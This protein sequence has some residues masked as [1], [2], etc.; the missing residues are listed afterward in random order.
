MTHLDDRN[1]LPR[2]LGFFD[3]TTTVVGAIIGTGI[4]LKASAISQLLPNPWHV[5][6][7]WAVAGALSLFGA[8]VITEL[9]GMYPHSGGLYLYLTEAFG[10]FVG[11]LFGWAMLALIQTG[12]LSG[13]AAGV[14]QATSTLLER[15]GHAPLAADEQM[16]GAM[17][18]V[19]L[20]TLINCVS[21]RAGASVQNFLTVLKSLGLVVLLAG[22]ALGGKASTANWAAGPP[23]THLALGAA[24]GL[25]MIKALWV[26]DGWIDVSFIAGEVE[27]PQRNL[28]RAMLFGMG[29]IIAI[30][31]AINA[32]FHLLMPVAD[33]QTSKTVAASAAGVLAGGGAV[34]AMSVV[35]VL[36]SLGGLN[37]SLLT[38][39]R[40][41]FAM[42]RE[43]MFFSSVG[44]IHPRFLTPHVSLI[45]QGIWSCG[46]LLAWSQFERITDNVIFCYW[47]FYA[48]GGVAMMVLRVRRPHAER[49]YVCPGYPLVPIA[50]VL[51]SA[52]LI[53]NTI[54]EQ[55][56]D[57]A[58]GLALLASGALLY[59][60]FRRG[61]DD[62]GDA[63]SEGQS[64]V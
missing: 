58:Q 35:I 10:P 16:I 29:F 61:P 9:G 40:V 42:A 39:G 11:F 17:D 31:V 41:Y 4:F 25:A 7:L 18:I 62:A 36:S 3:T 28:P 43:G 57:S 49:P 14:M 64:P 48:L 47:I 5:A 38:G 2:S 22:I 59:P 51:L 53:V 6:L 56:V 45:L 46:L 13:I 54:I 20:L 30:Y 34:L 21:V 33:V 63:P 44:A 27:N 23:N 32:G 19:M 1:D 15:F 8:L 52:A 26:Y 50:F 24:F 60:L 37:T 12:S 55:P